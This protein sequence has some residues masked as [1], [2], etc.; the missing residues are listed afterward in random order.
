MCLSLA[1]LYIFGN[2]Q[3]PQLNL[4]GHCDPSPSVNTCTHQSTAIKARQRLGIKVLLS[5][6]GGVGSYSLSSGNDAKQVANF[7]W[8]NY[9]GGR[10]NSRPRGDAVLDGID[11]DI[12]QGSGQ[13]CNELARS[14]KG[15]SQQKKVY[16]AAAPQCPFPDAHLDT[17]IKTGLFD[18]VWFN[19]ITT[20]NVNTQG[21]VLKTF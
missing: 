10:S 17:A 11:F 16:L 3:T 14:L 20:L 1:F 9:L 8:N 6:G 7:L 19:S 21:I 18:Y 15:F 2:G 13:Y 4:A 5:L 12:E